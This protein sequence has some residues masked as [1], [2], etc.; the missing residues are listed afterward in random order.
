M[1]RRNA[2]LLFLAFA[3]A[4]CAEMRWHKAGADEAA[5]GA[6]LSAC[7][8]LAQ[9]QAA[10]SGNLGLPPVSDPRFGAPVGPTQAEQRLQERQ[11]ADKCMTGKGYALVPAGK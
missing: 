11:A 4:A 6:D 7:S 5:L 9:E 2:S 3:L 8:K 10:R 1:T